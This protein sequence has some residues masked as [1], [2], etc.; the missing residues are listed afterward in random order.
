MAGGALEPDIEEVRQLGVHDIVV[1]GWVHHHCVDAS[2]LD[3]VEAVTRLASD[4]DRRRGAFLHAWASEEIARIFRTDSGWINETS[5]STHLPVLNDSPFIS[6][7]R[8]SE[9]RHLRMTTIQ[10]AKS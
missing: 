8:R 6:R 9:G 2:V 4:G 5:S 3:M 7:A 10:N 1:I